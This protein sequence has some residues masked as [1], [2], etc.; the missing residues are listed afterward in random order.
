M[1]NLEAASR[2]RQVV[3]CPLLASLALSSANRPP[4]I[5]RHF[6]NMSEQCATE[7]SGEGGVYTI[8]L[9]QGVRAVETLVAIQ[10]SVAQTEAIEEVA[11]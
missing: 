10:N 11:A 6:L 4:L 3:L 5:E 7:S 1:R 2:V 8:Q 9:V